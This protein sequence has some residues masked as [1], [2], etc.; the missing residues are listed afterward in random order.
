MKRAFILT[1]LACFNALPSLAAYDWLQLSS[2]ASLSRERGTG[3]VIGDNLY[4]GTGYQ[5]NVAM[6]DFWQYNTN[7]GAWTQVASL[8]GPRYGAVGFSHDNKGYVLTGK[9]DSPLTFYNDFNTYNQST[10]TWS[11]ML[12]Y[13]FTGR[14]GAVGFVIGNKAYYVGG[15][16]GSVSGPY[17][18]I[19]TA[20]D[21]IANSWAPRA[22][23]PG[24]LSHYRVAFVINNIAYVGSGYSALGG[25]DTYFNDFYSYNPVTDT[26]TALPPYPGGMRAGMSAVV[27]QQKA[28]V[29]LGISNFQTLQSTFYIFDPATGAWSPGPAFINGPARAHGIGLS[30]ATRAF[31]G[32]GF[33]SGNSLD[34]LWELTEVLS[35]NENPGTQASWY[36]HDGALFFRGENAAKGTLEVFDTNGKR[37]AQ[38]IGANRVELPSM[39]SGIYLWNYREGSKQSA[40]GKVLIP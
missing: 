35:L 39:S 4:F 26:W 1:A 17:S 36:Y 37:V 3:F 30:T 31:V 16:S 12:A 27:F 24:T 40:S 28:F 23:Y 29:G 2:P 9:R 15:N 18:N 11:S 10:N 8:N 21:F 14:Y 13:P 22:A 19:T 5:N 25:N 32:T 34:D 38:A 20:Y 33:S 7:T 6:N